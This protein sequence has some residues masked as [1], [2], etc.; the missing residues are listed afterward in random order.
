MPTLTSIRAYCY[1]SNYQKVLLVSNTVWGSYLKGYRWRFRLPKYKKHL[2]CVVSHLVFVLFE[3]LP[4]GL[5]LDIT[6]EMRFGCSLSTRLGNFE[7]RCEHARLGQCFIN[8]QFTLERLHFVQN[9]LC[10]IACTVTA[11]CFHW[12]WRMDCENRWIES[13]SVS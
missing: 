12:W 7:A 3:H 10:G 2:T 5:C 8:Y 11:S 9:R 13:G 1:C 6:L 4:L